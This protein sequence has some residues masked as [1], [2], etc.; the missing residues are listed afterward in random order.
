MKFLYGGSIKGYAKFGLNVKLACFVICFISVSCGNKRIF[1]GSLW[2][3]ACLL[4]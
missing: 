2:V 3:A 1:S 4:K